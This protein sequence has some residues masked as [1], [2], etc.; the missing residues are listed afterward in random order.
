[1]NR[2]RDD[3]YKFS[4][5]PPETTVENDGRWQAGSS[6]SSSTEEKGRN[7]YGGKTIVNTRT[8]KAGKNMVVHRNVKTE[9]NLPDLSGGTVQ[10][11]RS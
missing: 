10:E 1:M 8:V 9:E 5:K 7:E 6:S 3:P 2:D 4:S 11:N